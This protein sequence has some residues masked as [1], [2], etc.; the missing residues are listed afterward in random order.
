MTELS[1]S[2]RERLALIGVDL[3]QRRGQ[4]PD[5][6]ALASDAEGLRIRL[7]SGAGDWVLV[8][9]QAWRGE[10][11]A[12]MADIQATLGP[13]RCRFGQWAEPGSAGVGPAEMQARGVA[14]VLSFGPPPDL[15]D[16][17][18]LIQGPTLSALASEPDARRALWQALAPI[19]GA[20]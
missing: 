2:S 6:E 3:W 9:Q 13:E 5:A 18:M 7:L 19:V 20:Q 10:H 16:W 11:E 12:L 17:P 4:L 1:R 15:I 14:H 8:Q